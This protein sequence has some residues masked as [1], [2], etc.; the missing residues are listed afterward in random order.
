MRNKV[1]KANTIEILPAVLLSYRDAALNL[2]TFLAVAW[3]PIALFMLFDA[4]VFP[5]MHGGIT[6]WKST[7]PEGSYLPPLEGFSYNLVDFL[8]SAVFI[9]AIYRFLILDEEPGIKWLYVKEDTPER[10][11]SKIRWLYKEVGLQ[12]RQTAETEKARLKI[13]FYFRF[14][15]REFIFFLLSFYIFCVFL[16]IQDL[17][18]LVYL[19]N[20][21]DRGI[22][23][24]AEDRYYY[25]YVAFLTF[26]KGLFLLVY[27]KIIFMWPFLIC[28][29]HFVKHN[30][31]GEDFTLLF[32]ATRGNVF[33][34]LIVGLII[35]APYRLLCYSPFLMEQLGITDYQDRFS[36]YYAIEDQFLLFL[37]YFCLMADVVFI[38]S[39]YRNNLQIQEA[40]IHDEDKRVDISFEIDNILDNP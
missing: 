21:F 14:G 2:K 36:F 20:A 29:E 4:F 24:V 3:I 27:A 13:P 35:Y 15:R 30:S 28:E 12:T 8:L 19:Q 22:R 25:F 1:I 16:I 10:R 38:S 34:I 31:I 5:Y 40:L 17:V 32:A 7:L 11:K 6:H 26:L 39:I 23:Y 37:Y 18:E 33:K 9:A